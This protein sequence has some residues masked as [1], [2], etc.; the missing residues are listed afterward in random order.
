MNSIDR[1]KNNIATY[2][3]KSIKKKAE[4]NFVAITPFRVCVEV[5]SAVIVGLIVGGMIDYLAGTK[6]VFKIICLIL[7]CAASFRIVYKLANEK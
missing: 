1:L 7:G 6:S 4:K 2:K 5:V 3:A